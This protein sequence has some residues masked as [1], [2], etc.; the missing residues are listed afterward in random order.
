MK[1]PRYKFTIVVSVHILIINN[2]NEVLMA[3][4]PSTWEWGPGRWGMVGGKLYE[5]ENFFDAI[6]RKTKQELGFELEPEGL[7][8]VKQLIIK[9]RQVFM[10]FFVS[11]YKAQN[12]NGEM[13]EYKWFR[14][15]S[16]KE[17]PLN[18]FAEYFYKE[19]LTALLTKP[20]KLLPNNMINSLNYIK[21]TEESNYKD[22]F[23]GMIN[24]DYNPEIIPDFKK[25]NKSKK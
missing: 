12:I 8:Q 9:D 19:M 2:K 15:D 1:D 4:R 23:E 14:I 3:K 10:Y 25:W 21:L 11:K 22:W 13:A 24:K 5:E 20:I 16:I 17:T 7:Y 18:E 6:K